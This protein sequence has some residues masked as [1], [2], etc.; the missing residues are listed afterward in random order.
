MWCG[1]TEHVISTCED[2]QHGR[3]NVRTTRR[4]GL[5][6]GPGCVPRP[7]RLMTHTPTTDLPLIYST[8]RKLSNS[9]P[10]R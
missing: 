10:V 9:R 6:F 4:G 5:A 1:A 2:A 3:F 7:P 8:H